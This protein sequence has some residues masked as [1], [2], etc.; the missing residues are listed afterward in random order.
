MM[1]KY[2]EKI[3]L[4]LIGVL[5]YSGF[6]LAGSGQGVPDEKEIARVFTAAKKCIYNSEWQKA[7]PLLEKITGD[8]PEN[9]WTDDSL[10]WLAFSMN[11][12][13]L[14]ISDFDRILELKEEAFKKLIRL[15]QRYPSGKWAGSAK[16]LAL[17]LAAELVDKGL[18]RYKK[19]ITN[20]IKEDSGAE[21][22][23]AALDA[24]LHID[25]EKAFPVLE[26]IIR[27]NESP[28]MREKA[29]FV[30]AALDDPRVLPLLVNVALTD[31]D[32]SIKEKAIFWMGQIQTMESLK[33]LVKLYK[34]TVEIKLKKRIIFAISQ[35]D[36]DIAAKELIRI[37]RE[38]ENLELKKTVIFWLG[39][40]NSAEAQ[41]F[42]LKIIQQ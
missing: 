16:M 5:I 34:G 11:R 39:N 27:E 15:R 31:T 37:Y 8:F 35:R 33:Q 26:K 22:K 29:I 9:K 13:S 23:L 28:K 7:I 21:M 36:G 19:Y 42:L 30:L 24:L 40:C 4:I 38:E 32:A 2:M 14:E 18:K 3:I 6:S 25:R 20:G 1:M 41:Q 10:Y 17:E 12:L